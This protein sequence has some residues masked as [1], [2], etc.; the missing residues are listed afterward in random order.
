[1]EH[2]WDAHGH[3]DHGDHGDHGDGHKFDKFNNEV[4]YEKAG[5]GAGITVAEH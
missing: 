2:P 5:V 3:D 1:L 4:K